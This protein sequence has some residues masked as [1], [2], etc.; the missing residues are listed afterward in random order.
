MTPTLIDVSGADRTGIT[1]EGCGAPTAMICDGCRQASALHWW[2]GAERLAEPAEVSSGWC[3]LCHLGGA[4]WCAFCWPA[5]V[6][7]TRAELGRPAL[8]RPCT[9]CGGEG[10]REN[11]R[12]GARRACSACAGSGRVPA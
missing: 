6:V 10:T 5:A 4:A 7:A 3:R 2:A 1:C 9:T 12:V 8:S 11:G